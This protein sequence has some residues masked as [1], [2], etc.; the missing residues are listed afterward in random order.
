MNGWTFS[1]VEISM[2][3]NRER[4]RE[5]EERERGGGR[6]RREREM[7]ERRKSGERD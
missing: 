3:D 7:G 6:K 2:R 4:G 5:G 1:N